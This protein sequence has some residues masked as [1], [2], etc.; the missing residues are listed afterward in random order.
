MMSDEIHLSIFQK[1]KLYITGIVYTT[2][3]KRDG[4]KAELPFYAFKCPNH[5]L[6]ENYPH[7]YRNTLTCPKCNKQSKKLKQTK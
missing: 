1:F 7:G 2:H 3:R 4:W 5:G 6:V